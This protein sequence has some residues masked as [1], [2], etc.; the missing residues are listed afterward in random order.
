M[1]LF[2]VINKLSKFK[3]VPKVTNV[4]TVKSINY[5]DNIPKEYLDVLKESM[6]Q[7]YKKSLFM[8]IVSPKVKK[9]I[10][11]KWYDIKGH[12]ITSG[13][14]RHIFNRHGERAKLQKDEIP[15]TWNDIE[16][17]PLIVNKPDVLRISKKLSDSWN[18]V[19]KYEKLIWNKYYYLEYIDKKS[20]FLK[21]Q[22]MYINKVKDDVKNKI[23]NIKIKK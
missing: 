17:I 22:T 21:T 20:K 15:V 8:N 13:G 9:V 10:K 2:N 4:K 1:W 3:N 23:K 14:I 16:K 11:K 19:L 5:I 18:Q 12:Y 7:W 6:N